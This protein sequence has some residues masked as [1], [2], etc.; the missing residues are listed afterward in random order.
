MIM[1]FMLMIMV[2]GEMRQTDMMYFR[3][4]NRCNFFAGAIEKGSS[5]DGQ[6]LITAWCEPKMVPRETIFWD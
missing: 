6:Y 5:D 3:N 1:A 4:V 2:N